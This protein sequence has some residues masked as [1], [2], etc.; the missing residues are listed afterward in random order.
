MPIAGT[1]RTP[2]Q[3]RRGISLGRTL[4]SEDTK[5]NGQGDFHHDKKRLDDKTGEQHSVIRAVE[6]AQ[7][8]VFGADEDRADQVTDPGRC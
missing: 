6:D 2:F 3:D 5:R 1:I 8:E 7:S 4:A